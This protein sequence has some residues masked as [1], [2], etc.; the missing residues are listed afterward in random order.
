[1]GG[2]VKTGPRPVSGKIL[3]FITRC[4]TTKPVKARFPSLVPLCAALLLPCSPHAR[5]QNPKL[6][7]SDIKNFKAMTDKGHLVAQVELQTGEQSF[8]H[9]RYDRYPAVERIIEEDGAVFARPKGKAWLKSDD[10][11][12]TGDAAG[13][14]KSAQLDNFAEI[15]NA[16]FQEPAFHDMSQGGTVWRFVGKDE[17]EGYVAYAYERSREKPHPNGVYP[18][19]TFIKRDGDK[20]GRLLLTMVTGQLVMGDGG[21]LVPYT[22]SFDYSP[23][24]VAQSQPEELLPPA[25]KI[26]SGKPVKV[27]VFATG[28][29]NCRVTGIVSGRDFDLTV[30]K[31]DGSY[32]QIAVGG[33]CW[34]SDDG[35]KTWTKQAETDR[36]YYFLAHSPINY[37]A[38]E[39]IPP[40]EKVPP[41]TD[42]DKTLLHLRFKSPQGERY[43]GDRANYWLTTKDGSVTGIARFYGPL[44]FEKTYSTSD[45][46]YSDVAGGQGVL[47]PP[48]NPVAAPHPG[49]EVMLMKT[50][51]GMA[52]GVWK[53]DAQAEFAKK[54][55]VTGLISG[56]DYDLTET[57]A[58]GKPVVRQITIGNKSWGTFDNGKTWRKESADDRALYNL[59]YAGLAPDRMKPPFEAAGSEQHDGK[60]WLHIRETGYPKPA[61]DRDVW[62]YWILMDGEN[63]PVSVRRFAGF[64]LM[65]GNPVYCDAVFTRAEEGAAIKPPQ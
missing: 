2:Q 31:P 15:V 5:G 55:R 49:P 34:R 28:D 48:G 23:E 54:A 50:L 19:F 37:G 51:Q 33:D 24:G 14:E 10:W 59:I 53:V 25:K 22:I 39:M 52:D 17:E 65:E 35:G 42:E 7:P 16:A 3:S 46:R 9:Y 47:P 11:G 45:V 6:A 20:D 1:M 13:E 26:M 57:T 32:R 60:T 63:K 27:D 36:R 8:F 18:R 40:F 61:S 29:A 56:S 30:E 41:A 58:E 64:V 38:H 43:V 4:F 12:K 44:V 62:Q 21:K